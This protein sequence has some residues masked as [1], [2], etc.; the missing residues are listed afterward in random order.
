MNYYI[1]QRSDGGFALLE[2]GAN[3]FI[4]VGRD[5]REISRTT[6]PPLARDDSHSSSVE[7]GV[8]DGMF[9]GLSP[10][11][12][13]GLAGLATLRHGA[14]V[15][16]REMLGSTIVAII[17]GVAGWLMMRR[18][19]ASKWNR[20]QW[21]IFCALGGVGGVLTLLCVRTSVARVARLRCAHCGRRRRVSSELCE[22]CGAAFPPPAR[23]GVEVFESSETMV[24]PI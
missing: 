7:D 12:V 1:A 18:Y 3:L 6:L 21:T 11:A 24:T 16:A 22:H 19:A 13:V 4:E 15:T 20:A 14:Q 17:V 2:N 9:V 10:P 8:E 23:T 5:G